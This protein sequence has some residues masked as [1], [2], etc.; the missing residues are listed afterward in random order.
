[1][2]SQMEIFAVRD[3]E[4][5]Y[6]G[7]V[8]PPAVI[9]VIGAGG[10]GSNAV[11]RM[12]EAELSGVQFIAVNTDVQDLMRKSRADI[13]L[14]IGSKLTGGRGAGGRPA[15]GEDAAKEDQEKISETL[16]GADMVF[17]TAGM[18][19]G[20]GTGSA[21][22]IAKI[23][24]DLGALT[25]GVVTKPFANEGIPKMRLAD[26]G[27]KKLRDAVDALIV[28]PNQNLLKMVDR[29]TTYAQAYR[30]ADEIL[31]HGVQGISDLITKVGE[32]NIDFAD[33]EATL[34]GQGDALMGIGIGSGDSRARDAADSAIDN[35]LLEDTSIEGA[36]RI[37]INIAGSA[38]ISMIEVDEILDAVG[39]KADRNAEIIHGITVDHEMG[40]NIKVTV[41]A[42]G[43]QNTGVVSARGA[44]PQRKAEPAVGE[45]ID[46][47]RFMA[48][49]GQRSN[50][51]GNEAYY[52][53]VNPKEYGENLSI[54][55][56]VRKNSPD[57]DAGQKKA[58]G[59]GN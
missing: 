37:L 41:I 40:E 30:M 21:P 43:F 46:H 4:P 38:D 24:K 17:V 58:A 11:N 52:G 12:I 26:E 9:K 35:P 14:Q 29:K 3:F 8:E 19:G 32:I 6:V 55:T 5:E 16:R 50:N 2:T 23:A 54:P 36:T 56:Y 34:R 31:R 44:E 42:T 57:A 20:T 39:K 22:V 10:G 27:I 49:L 45:I 7:P 28:I 13:K 18:G 59:S 25:V 47:E 1:M 53:Y 33:V 48:M 51:R 15:I